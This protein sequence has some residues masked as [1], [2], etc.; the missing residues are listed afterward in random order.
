MIEIDVSWLIEEKVDECRGQ[1]P[2]GNSNN[3][4]EKMDKSRL[5]NFAML[6]KYLS[7]THSVQKNAV[8]TGTRDSTS[9]NKKRKKLN[10]AR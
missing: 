3:K 4:K 1:M 10:T 6:S 8:L 2:G 7:L 5:V 9:T